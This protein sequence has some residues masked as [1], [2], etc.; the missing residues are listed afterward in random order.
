MRKIQPAQVAIFVSLISLDV[1]A[2][3][4][5]AT[6]TMGLIPLGDFR[7]VA[8]ALA[9]IV[10]FYGFAILTYRLFLMLFPLP[11]GEIVEGSRQERIYHVYVLFYLLC[12]NSIMRSGFPPIPL[13]RVFYLLLGA[14]LG[15]NTYSSGLIYD[16]PFVEIGSN[17]VV[18]ESAILIPHVI[19]GRRLAHYTIRVGDNVTI[20]ANA[21][22]LPGVS[23][24]DGAIVATGAVVPKNTQ[25]AANE[26][27]GGVPARRL[28]AKG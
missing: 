27:W 10:C 7:G 2:A 8:L 26:V 24:G 6:W 11:E 17:S 28:V 9:G 19:E 16:P 3:V 12:F 22:I 20:G 25:I 18:G 4:G 1:A 13:M 21:V 14:K 23:I 15:P 5:L